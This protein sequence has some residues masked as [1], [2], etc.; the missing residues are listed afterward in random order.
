MLKAVGCE[1]TAEPDPSQSSC[2][3][4][5]KI[6]MEFLRLSGPN[7]LALMKRNLFVEHILVFILNTKL[8]C[9]DRS[10]GKRMGH[11]EMLS[12]S[13]CHE[14][15]S[16]RNMAPSGTQ[17]LGQSLGTQLLGQSLQVSAFH[18]HLAKHTQ[19][20]TWRPGSEL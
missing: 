17:L 18:P 20:L 12:L 2:L 5:S 6:L 14:G 11:R 16:G 8:E 13:S 9:L 19:L 7:G 4:L 15:W 10:W 1:G 3:P